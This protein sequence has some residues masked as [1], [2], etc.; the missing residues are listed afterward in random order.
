MENTMYEYHLIT[1]PNKHVI[2]AT[3]DLI[4]EEL[5]NPHSSTV[6][7]D[8]DNK[9]TEVNHDYINHILET[10]VDPTFHDSCY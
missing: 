7:R 5:E 4:N 2:N 6:I 10:S 3:D 8:I 1:T 9:L